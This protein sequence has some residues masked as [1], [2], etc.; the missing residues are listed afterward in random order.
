MNFFNLYLPTLQKL[1]GL[2]FVISLYASSGTVVSAAKNQDGLV[3][4]PEDSSQLNLS[5]VEQSWL[6]VHPK[7]RIGIMNAWPPISYQKNNQA[8]GVD[9]DFIRL[10]N[11]R[12][13][14]VLEIVPAPF[15]VNYDRV[16]SKKL[17]AIMD[18]TPNPSREKHFNFTRSYLEIPH[19]IIGLKSGMYFESE[20]DLSG[21]TLALEK[22]FG[23][24]KYF[25]KNYP[26]I[27][28]VE[29]D[30]TSQCLGAVS[31]GVADA[32]AGNRA[33]AMYI[34]EQ[35][36]ITNLK[37]HGRLN[38]SGSIL[39]VGV[40]KDW[41]EAATIID[42][43][44]ASITVS[45]KRGILDKWVGDSG[46]GQF[47]SGLGLTV[48]EL[49]WLREHP[50]IRVHNEKAWAPINF[51][52]FGKP[53]GFSIEVM[54]LLAEKI[55]I[56]VNY[57][58]GPSWAEFVRMIKEK[59]LDVMLNIVE[60][61]KR[62]EFL[63]FT[64]PYFGFAQVIFTR[65]GFP[66]VDSIND[67]AGKKFAIPKG[68]YFEEVLKNYPEVKVVPV[69]NSADAI[70]AVSNGQADVLLDVMPVVN[71][72]SQQMLITNLKPG[73]RLGLDEDNVIS[74]SIGVR[75]DW[76]ILRDI[77]QKALSAVTENEMQE[78]RNRWLQVS[79][80]NLTT[81]VSLT[82]KEKKWLSQ[83]PV[84]RVS[85]ETDYPP[86]DFVENG[87]PAGF[88]ID[89]LNL[90]ARRAG[91][92]LEYVP[93]TLENLVEKA[94]K[95]EIDILHTVFYTSNR[96]S[97]LSFT[98]PYKSVLNVIYAR[99]D[100]SGVNSLSDLKGKRVM[101]PRGDTIAELLP[102][103]VP[104]A[105][106][107][108]TDSYETILKWISFGKAD[109]TVMDSAVA[110]YLIRKN[111]LTNVKP[112][113]EADIPAGDR[114]PRYRLAVRKDWPELRS[115]LQ[116]T[117]DTISRDE[118]AKLETRWFGLADLKKKRS[119]K[120]TTEETA[121]LNNHPVIRVHNEKDWPPFNY[122]EYESPR[123]LS[124]DYM[125]LL[126]EELGLKIEYKTGPSWNEFLDMIKNK[127][128]DVMLN[129]VKTTDREKYL[130]YTP[131]YIRNPNVIVSTSKKPYDTISQLYGKTVAIPR[132]YYQEEILAKSFPQI[133][134][135]PVK[136][137][138]S[139]LKAV[140]FGKAV[141]TLGEQAV[142]EYVINRN[143]ITGLKISGEIDIGNPDLANL[144][145]GIRNDWPLLQS[146]LKKAMTGV[147]PQQ[148]IRIQQKWIQPPRTET[149]QFSESSDGLSKG[150]LL[151]LLGIIAAVSAFLL[152]I[153]WLVSRSKKRDISELYSSK[154]LKRA[155]LVFIA[156]S[157]G[158]I[159]LAA[160]LRLAQ[161]KQEVG[162]E[163]KSNL[164]TVRN[165]SH[166][167]LKIWVEGKKR[168]LK[169]VLGNPHLNKL[170]KDQL[171]SP[172]NKKSL[173][174][175]P[176]LIPLRKFFSN[177]RNLLGNTRFYLISPDMVTIGSMTDQDLGR[178]NT[179][180]ERHLRLL[181]TAFFGEYVMIPPVRSDIFNTGSKDKP[182]KNRS[183]L[184]IAGPVT[185]DEG[186]AVAILA[187]ALDPLEDFSRIV[188]SGWIG[189]TGETY[190]FDDQAI[191]LS[192]S[193]FKDQ[194]QD[195]GLLKQGES[196]ILNI[197]LVD[198]GEPLQKGFDN[199][200][201]SGKTDLT[202]MANRA[203]SGRDG[204]NIEGY[205]DYQ[206][207][208]VVGAWLWDHE[209][210]IGLTTEVHWSE[211]YN[212]YTI[213][214][215]TLIITLG[216]TVLIA[217]ILTGFS[218]W[219]G[220]S[221]TRSLTQSKDQLEV[222]VEERTADL[223]R[224][225]KRFRDLLESAP[226][227]IIIVNEEAVI[228]L[229]NAQTEI[230]FGYNR[231]ELIGKKIETMIP[232]RFREGH[233]EKRDGFIQSALTSPVNV[234]RE[235]IGLRKNGEEFP[236]EVSLNPL[237]TDEGMLVSA[238]VRDIT[239]RIL[240]ENALK[241]SEE[242][243]RLILDSVGEGIF[244]VDLDGKTMFINPSACFLLGYTDNELLGE[245]IHPMIHHTRRD[246]SDYPVDEC[247]MKKAYIQGKTF[248]VV[249][250]VL[251]KKDGNAL[252]VVYSS[253]PIV[254][255]NEIVGA[256]ITF[257]DVTQKRKA[258]EELKATESR[259]RAYF[260]Y[261]QVGTAVTHP[262]KGWLEVNLRLQQ[263]LGYSDEELKKLSWVNL[264]HPEDLEEDVKNFD[265]MIKGDI[266]N[267]T[268]EKRL[269]HKNGQP[270][271]V[272]LS[273]SCVRD[274]KGEV[275]IVLASMIDITESKQTQQELK[276][277]FDELERFRRM[278]IGRELKMIE[279]KKEINK[280]LTEDNLPEKYKIH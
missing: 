76:T 161:F 201:A 214:R 24:V 240:A 241:E 259:F 99:D 128:L 121:W 31:R 196:G 162:N 136:D 154:E 247:P 87:R 198:P 134:L 146:A 187:F 2:I 243:N 56:K 49:N 223:T 22:G 254:K 16:V 153:S 90:I 122:F 215:N 64:N 133:K 82:Q 117:M 186:M 44:L 58:D 111:T 33:V 12:L 157:I 88:S 124:I 72:L 242:K 179:F 8:Q 199:R 98:E 227:S 176:S 244:G 253:T 263:M 83:H 190:L 192:E 251:W 114:D 74:A 257:Q 202:F 52:R 165:A 138:L 177:S 262:D 219:I 5:P 212:Q 218:L 107:V 63:S 54:N 14:G 181:Q 226:D 279:L 84:I 273:V 229:V 92:R 143:M 37:V 40:R 239:E 30:N 173:L 51:N 178:K 113:A 104:D 11:E 89:Y 194:I 132:G 13:N 34:M 125:N 130:L 151:L 100:I 238:A 278:A 195:L 129:I 3:F 213:I 26:D 120:L 235:L 277:K 118:M 29:Y 144:H 50:V 101:L 211:A 91:L 27:N 185:D 38:K 105:V 59:K 171:R 80:A 69:K 28:I 135:L 145:I 4:K 206:G 200:L 116:K 61:A 164:Q 32:Y 275:N 222:R 148:M 280:S 96:E 93:D 139:G 115:I 60:S 237:K 15:K 268:L 230:L 197:K 160:S 78:I 184:F 249:D 168:E 142:L 66:P 85:N 209:L 71:Y 183:A 204:F 260:E 264:T 108:F 6:S 95:R 41:P 276:T 155:G 109:A 246:G 1:I 224:L 245:K 208:L 86:F 25:K 191:L 45:E 112:A 73:G 252:D 141:A 269:I 231:N 180:G 47:A 149:K 159:V 81:Q 220:Q 189:E 127:R 55:G 94:K 39:A 265:Q 228:S 172:R 67:L 250:E 36:M 193:R 48:K 10:L 221:A 131:P 169:I 236:V 23:N 7:I 35:E 21:E 62:K 158:I 258:E 126:A 232:H 234:K 225:E 174:E 68:F 152:L 42:K 210:G 140:S 119:V 77:L 150:Y 103:L 137:A 156:L 175:S 75:K 43:A 106:F 9:S 147:T 205:R 274:E 267:Y 270:V 188:Q 17:D 182:E 266:D 261:G 163:L 110:N 65:K 233:P 255:D 102:K 203:I 70:Q 97:Y 123:G 256:V 170:I 18:L 166:Q 79:S 167:M 216:I 271:Y 248:N 217:L 207:R 46:T 53:S 272:N 19:V 57:I 20:K